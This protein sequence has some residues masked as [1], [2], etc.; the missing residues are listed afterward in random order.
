MFYAALGLMG[1]LVAAALVVMLYGKAQLQRERSNY[2][3]FEEVGAGGNEE[4][5]N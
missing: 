4:K 5:Q 2:I 1:A 3:S